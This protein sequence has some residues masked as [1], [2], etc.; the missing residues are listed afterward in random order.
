MK[1]TSPGAERLRI[2]SVR[3]ASPLSSCCT[4]SERRRRAKPLQMRKYPSARSANEGRFKYGRLWTSSSSVSRESG[5]G[6]ATQDQ[7]RP[8]PSKSGTDG[9][10]ERGRAR[11][12]LSAPRRDGKV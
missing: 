7:T 1:S 4:E 9:R 10:A 6:G 3:R 11:A 8:A 12:R 2:E 5:S